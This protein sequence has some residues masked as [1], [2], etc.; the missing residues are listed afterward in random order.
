[1]SRSDHIRS[2]DEAE[3]DAKERR[4]RKR[5][6]KEERR[7]Q[8]ASQS[9]AEI[10]KE[11]EVDASSS[12]E[13]SHREREDDELEREGKERKRKRKE[14]KR[15]QK[16]TQVQ[17]EVV[18]ENVVDA[19][20]SKEA[21]HSEREDDELE[22]ERKERKRKKKEERR[23]LKSIQDQAELM[24][25]D[26]VHAS[27][28]K[29]APLRENEAQELEEQSKEERRR[30]KKLK[31]LQKRKRE[32]DLIL[33]EVT[34]VH[35]E[36]RDPSEEERQ[37]TAVQAE[38]PSP[39]LDAQ[40]DADDTGKRKKQKKKKKKDK[41][42]SKAEQAVNA[43][44][45]E[46]LSAKIVNDQTSE[47]PRLDEEDDSPTKP[48]KGERKRA[49]ELRRQKKEE[50]KKKAIGADP[51]PLPSSSGSETSSPSREIVS[52]PDSSPVKSNV[53]TPGASASPSTHKALEPP[54]ASQQAVSASPDNQAPLPAPPQ[55]D[56]PRPARKR[57]ISAMIDAALRKKVTGGS[58]GL[59]KV[60]RADEPDEIDDSVE[61]MGSSL[62][63]K[64]SVLADAQFLTHKQ[65]LVDK[66][67]R[68]HQLKW[69]QEARGLKIKNGAFSSWEQDQMQEAIR[70]FKEVSFAIEHYNTSALYVLTLPTSS[71]SGAWHDS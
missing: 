29:G 36:E 17:A 50:E 39:R 48:S 6:R 66:L 67:Y 24:Q 9:Q 27:S 63:T 37:L 65:M 54:L 4:E 5:Q 60:K 69:L 21:L 55:A 16:A 70:A 23:G 22:K 57:N 61:G 43:E 13:A 8:K 51:L 40:S 30:A 2:S 68:S 18:E 20:S 58:L 35:P 47:R 41:E 64:E 19:S 28:R 25:D 62:N 12:K 7:A 53:V 38:P 52:F 59:R 45:A 14:E 46:P 44:A 34:A 49:K 32:L 42:K 1:M 15:L 10:V 56:V 11:N 3:A 26:I 31:K 71:Y 33:E